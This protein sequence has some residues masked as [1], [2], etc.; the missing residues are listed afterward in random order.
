MRA[1]VINPTLKTIT[2]EDLPGTDTLEIILA[3]V[4]PGGERGMIQAVNIGAQHD[5]WIDEEALLRPWIDQAFFSIGDNPP[6]G[7]IGVI[8]SHTRDGESHDCYAPIEPV[9]RVIRWVAPQDVVIPAPTIQTMSKD[10]F[11]PEGKPEVIGGGPAFWTFEN[12]GGRPDRNS[13]E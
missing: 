13:K 8:L 11:E 3:A 5:L 2:V 9:Q 6:I 7:G 10:T 12:H 1:I 4:F